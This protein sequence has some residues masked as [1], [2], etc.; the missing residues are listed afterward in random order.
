[1]IESDLEKVIQA[2]EMPV[3]LSFDKVIPGEYDFVLQG[4]SRLWNIKVSF[5][6]QFPYCLPSAKLLDTD[7]IGTLAHVNKN[8]TICLEEGDSVLVDYTRPLDIVCLFLNQIVSL[9]ERMKLGIYQDELL[10]EFEGYFLPRKKINS[11]YYAQN[12]LEWIYLRQGNWNKNGQPKYIVPLFISDRNVSTPP[13]FSNIKN[14]GAFQRSKILHIPL[15]QSILPPANGE[16]ITSTYI[17]AAKQHIDEKNR[18][19][20]TK[21]LKKTS[22]HK[23]FFILLSMPRSSGERSQLLLRFDAEKSLPHPLLENNEEWSITPYSV[24]RHNKE[25]LLERGGAEKYLLDNKVA[26]IGC[27]SVGGEITTMLAKAGI[28]ELTLVDHDIL[29]ADNIYRHRLGGSYL[30]FLPSEKTGAINAWKKVDALAAMLK[31]DLPHITV[32]SKPL[33]FEQVI[34]DPD[35]INADVIVIAIGSPSVS[36]IINQ[37]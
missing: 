33:L 13:Q 28:G 37:T 14:L 31:Q 21:H 19:A 20:L 27:G 10:D 15:D 9:L 11:F 22:P 26:I 7:L 35:I 6:E 12:K 17:T 32:N 18:K 25:Y 16:N 24:K 30:N 1:M 34:N 36:L 5:P 8:G 2:I 3:C 4:K 23:L 29:D